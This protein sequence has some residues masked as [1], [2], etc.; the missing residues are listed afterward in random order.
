MSTHE[1]L[2]N[3]TCQNSKKL[4]QSFRINES[5]IGRNFFCVTIYHVPQMY[6]TQPEILCLFF[7][8][9]KKSIFNSAHM[10]ENGHKKIFFSRE[11]LSRFLSII[12]LIDSA[13][14][15]HRFDSVLSNSINQ[16]TSSSFRLHSHMQRVIINKYAEIKTISFFLPRHFKILQ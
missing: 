1:V 14:S 9:E 4:R 8:H 12:T 15:E 10:N 2:K 3:S 13:T 6:Q 7:P 16:S 11:K 5:H